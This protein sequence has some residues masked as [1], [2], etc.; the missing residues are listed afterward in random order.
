MKSRKRFNNTITFT[1]ALITCV[2]LILGI[3]LCACDKTQNEHAGN[4]SS[5]SEAPTESFSEES[6]SEESVSEESTYE[7]ASSETSEAFSFE[8]LFNISAHI[9][10]EKLSKVSYDYARY[11]ASGPVLHD[12]MG[13][14]DQDLLNS[15]IDYIKSA[16]F[17]LIDSLT[18]DA[19]EYT[20]TF[21]EGDRSFEFKFNTEYEF[22]VD[23]KVYVSSAKYP[24]SGKYS[25]D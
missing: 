10:L 8:E 12:Y 21:Y 3:L 1:K 9:D 7:G 6:I 20:A 19:G 15:V 11:A 17:T 16:R 13:S 24:F 23:G 2:F 22:V 5:S 4:E 25:E 18:P 14:T